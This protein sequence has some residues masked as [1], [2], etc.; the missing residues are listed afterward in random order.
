MQDVQEFRESR[1]HVI[2]L[3]LVFGKIHFTSNSNDC[4]FRVYKHLCLGWPVR[5]LMGFFFLMGQR[6]TAS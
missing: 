4:R 3:C 2:V 1:V 6:V 5:S